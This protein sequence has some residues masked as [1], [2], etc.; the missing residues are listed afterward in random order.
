M[1][2]LNIKFIEKENV[3][4][5]SNFFVYKKQITSNNRSL[6]ITPDHKNHKIFKILTR[7]PKGT[8]ER[9]KLIPITHSHTKLQKITSDHRQSHTITRNDVILKNDSRSP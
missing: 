4:R 3:W 2:P 5:Q 9:T 7:S 8:P 1:H 6:K